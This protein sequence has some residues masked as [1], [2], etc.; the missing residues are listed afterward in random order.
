MSPPIQHGV[1]TVAVLLAT[2]NG[3]QF[4]AEQIDSI[5]GQV[6]VQVRII[7]S[8]DASRDDTLHLLEAYAQSTDRIAVLPKSGLKLGN[9][10][11]NFM[12]LIH[13][14]PIGDAQFVAFSD[15]DDIWQRDKLKAATDRLISE[16][17]SGYSCN[18]TAFWPNGR[19]KLLIKSQPQRAH[20]HFFESAGAGCTFVLTR[21]AFDELR[22]LIR[23]DYGSARALRIH[24]WTIYA[25]VREQGMKWIIDSRSSIEYRQHGQNELGANV[26]MR[27]AVAR[28]N[29][30]RDGSFRLEALNLAKIL[31]LEHPIL[32][33][34][35]RLSWADRIIL[36]LRARQCRR[37]C[38]DAAVLAL[39]FLITKKR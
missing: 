30:L 19:R 16:C 39:F 34:L 33:R 18:I 1:S 11:R 2:H 4:L 26:G 21:Q 17:A 36:A 20:D 12:R 10:N 8:D 32:K 7:A 27:A 28:F 31:R 23:A 38:V 29:Q 6:G 15:Q 25:F 22:R 9:A 37:R 13:D 14:A 5:L 24:D 3:G 35:Q